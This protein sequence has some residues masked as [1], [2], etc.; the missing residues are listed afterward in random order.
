MIISFP[1]LLDPM[2]TLKRLLGLFGLC[3][4]AFFA[5]VSHASTMPA[6]DVL[7]RNVSEEVLDIVRQDR[8]ARTSNPQR[9]LELVKAKVLPHFNF[10]RMTRLALGREGRQ[11]TPEQITALSNEFRTLLVRT[12]SKALTEYRDQEIVFRPFTM[13][14]G[15]TDVRVRTEIRQRGAKPIPMDYYLELTPSG[16]KVYDV[17]VGGASLVITYRS[18]FAEE[19]RKGGIDGLL[20]SLRARNGGGEV[21]TTK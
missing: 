5:S 4:L 9:T 15:E 21:A 1:L 17:E 14:P 19:I 10:T 20:R 18:S 12:Y 7:I 6:P 13:K 16:W 8:E 2:N 11:A 3:A